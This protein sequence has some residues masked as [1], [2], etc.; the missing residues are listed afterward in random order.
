MNISGIE[1][2]EDTSIGRDDLVFYFL[3]ES[4][5]ICSGSNL[6]FLGLT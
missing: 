6:I 4:L 5:K 1:H 3:G 2:G